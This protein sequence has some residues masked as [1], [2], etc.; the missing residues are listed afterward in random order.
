MPLQ[1]EYLASPNHSS[2]GGTA[3]TMILLHATVGSYTSSLDW[4]RNP[5]TK[6]P[7]DR[8]ST[9]YLI[10][11]DGH[12]AQL[13]ADDQTAWHAGRAR[14]HGIT[15]INEASIGIE[16]EN[17]NDGHD[18]YPA[19]QLDAARLLCRSLIAAYHILRANVVRHLDVATPAGR[20]TDP[21][22]F[23]WPAFVDGL[24]APAVAAP[25][26]I[27]AGAL[28][29][30][31]PR[32]K[33]AQCVAW[34]SRHATGGYNLA[35]VRA[36]VAAYFVSSATAGIDPLLAIAQMAHETGSLTSWWSQRPRRNPA[37]IGV[38]GV[39]G[40]GLV[41][42]SWANHAIPAHV[43]RLLAYATLPGQGTTAQQ[44]LIASA[45]ALRPLPSMSRGMARQL[46][47]LDGRWAVPGVG[48]ASKIATIATAITR[49]TP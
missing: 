28:L 44:R 34:L 29:L 37:G 16:L 10:R 31:A 6:N 2:R 12:I 40:A 23:P 1:I 17:A 20:K 49:M 27:D 14:W 7:D 33:E 45:L 42:A 35:D 26:P 39:G 8:V 41:F 38:T 47:G 15:A 4:L 32:A 25:E 36:I 24:Y 18:P 11:R 5:Q 19:A 9:H 13:V 30:H 46:G 48:Y 22:G 21:A 43:G 3:I